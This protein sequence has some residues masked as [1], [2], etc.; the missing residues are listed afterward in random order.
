MFARRVDD[1]RPSSRDLHRRAAL[2]SPQRSEVTMAKTVRRRKS[3]RRPTFVSLTMFRALESELFQIRET[4]E[5]VRHESSDNLRRCGELQ[6]EVDALK[7]AR[8]F[9]RQAEYQR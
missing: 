3:L 4:I 8:E 5:S 2:R 6:V 9:L 7:K 1:T